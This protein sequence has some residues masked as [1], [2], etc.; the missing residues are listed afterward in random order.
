MRPPTTRAPPAH[1]ACSEAASASDRRS[2]SAARLCRGRPRGGHR[3][4]SWRGR[5]RGRG[6]RAGGAGAARRGGL[7]GAVEGRAWGSGCIGVRVP[8]CSNPHAPGRR[9]RGLGA[10][11]CCSANTHVSRWALSSASATSDS[12]RLRCCWPCLELACSAV[13][14]SSHAGTGA[15]HVRHVARMP[16]AAGTAWH[17]CSLMASTPQALSGG[18]PPVHPN[19]PGGPCTGR[20]G[21]QVHQLGVVHA[22]PGVCS[23]EL[24]QGVQLLRWAVVRSSGQW[25]RRTG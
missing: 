20:V 22:Q 11:G 4:S 23:L 18:R 13:L 19:T 14:H 10:H 2:A 8:A 12:C 6:G 15:C 16:R 3:R 24:A 21:E 5:S 25:A 7:R 1:A 17:D 9:A